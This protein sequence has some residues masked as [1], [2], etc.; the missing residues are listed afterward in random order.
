MKAFQTLCITVTISLLTLIQPLHATNNYFLPGDAFFHSILT[1]ESIQKREKEQE[2]VYDYRFVC[3]PAFCGYAGYSELKLDKQNKE[4]A[5]NIHKAYFE[6]RKSISLKLQRKTYK[7]APLTNTEKSSWKPENFEE[8]NGL[9]LLFYNEDYDWKRRNIAVKYNEDWLGDLKKFGFGGGRYCEF[10]STAD[11]VVAS[12]ARGKY[13][14]PLN[15]QLPDTPIEKY[16]TVNTPMLPKGKLKA[17]ILFDRN[18]KQYFEMRNHKD[19]IEVTNK[20][21]NRYIVHQ[22]QWKLFKDVYGEDE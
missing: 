3:E 1:L 2:A 8:T 6:I 15:V 7:T 18:F 20:G 17:L 16:K 19:L 14:P 11:A 9:S 21:I 22:K 4:L 5:K 13:I 12:W 10:V